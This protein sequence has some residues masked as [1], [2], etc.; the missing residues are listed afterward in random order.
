MSEDCQFP[1]NQAAIKMETKVSYNQ[2]NPLTYLY[3]NANSMTYR[4]TLFI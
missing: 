2:I 3:Y 1:I 4:Y